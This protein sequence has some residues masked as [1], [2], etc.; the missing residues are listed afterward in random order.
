MNEFDI[1]HVETDHKGGLLFDE[2]KAH[3]ERLAAMLASGEYNGKAAVSLTL[4]MK[5]VG[6][7]SV[8]I[9]PVVKVTEPTKSRLR[10]LAYINKRTG[11][12]LVQ[13]PQM[14]IES[15]P[16]ILMPAFRGEK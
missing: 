11:G 4:T 7:D 8:E 14:D 5:L 3:L 13:P 6:Q 15:V 10:T 2:V 12:L 16:G 9:E 1:S